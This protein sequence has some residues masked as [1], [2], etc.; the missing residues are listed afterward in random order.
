MTL[1]CSYLSATAA[2]AIASLDD[3][4]LGFVLPCEDL[5]PRLPSSS[6]ALDTSS[7]ISSMTCNPDRDERVPAVS[8]EMEALLSFIWLMEQRTESVA[9]CTIS[10]GDSDGAAAAAVVAIAEKLQ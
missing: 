5:G 7:S 3:D 10:S 8:L 9:S 1:F 2:I 4:A 6:E